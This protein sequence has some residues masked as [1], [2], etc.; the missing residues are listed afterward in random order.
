[1]DRT[2]KEQYIFGSILLLSNKLQAYGNNFIED[3]TMKQWFLLMLISKMNSK[4]P[5]VKEIA[6]FSGST[7]QNIKKMIEPLNKKGYIKVEK[8]KNDA[9]AL[10]ISL[11]SKT[12]EFFESY[13]DIAKTCSNNVFKDVNSDLLN[14]TAE[15][16]KILL[17]F[18]ENDITKEDSNG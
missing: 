2:D 3:I 10:S 6:N 18:F 11:T 5:T 9:R 7:R 17:D 14:S 13:K 12:Y 16:V 15:T 4:S 8:S 1:M